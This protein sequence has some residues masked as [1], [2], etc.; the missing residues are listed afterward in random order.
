MTVNLAI[1][2]VL[3]DDF[4]GDDL[5]KNPVK[6][7]PKIRQE[8]FKNLVEGIDIE[9][10]ADEFDISPAR[11]LKLQYNFR[12][13]ISRMRAKRDRQIK[14]FGEEF[15]S[16]PMI[17]VFEVL[18]ERLLIHPNGIVYLD[19]RRTTFPRIIAVAN[20]ILIKK[21]QLPV[22]YPGVVDPCDRCAP[23]MKI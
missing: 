16:D 3:N 21:N 18:G 11:I 6:I 8:I 15:W 20:D 17:R 10:I 22:R 23:S 5:P 1:N 7:T 12:R 2:V 13:E 4:W 9:L 14:K 19:G